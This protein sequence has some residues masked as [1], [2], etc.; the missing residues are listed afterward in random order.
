[1]TMP[2]ELSNLVKI[3]HDRL[4][5]KDLVK[6]QQTLAVGDGTSRAIIV[7]GKLWVNGSKLHVRFMGG[8]PAQQ[9][10]AQEQAKW[11][12]DHANLTFE[13]DNAPNAEI[14]IAFDSSDGA[15]SYIGTDASTIPMNQPTMNLG[16]LDGGTAAHEFG[17]A[18]GLAHEHQNPAGGIQWNE[19]AVIRD[20]S[21]P[22][23]SWDQATIRH[24]VLDKYRAD[25]IRGTE[26]DHDSIMLYFFPDAWVKNGKGTKANEVL[27]KLDKEFVASAQVYPKTTTTPQGVELKIGAPPTTAQIGVPGEEDL[28]KFTVTSSS[29]YV[30]ETG[31]QTDVAMKLFGPNSQ[32][33]LINEDD[34]G[35]I[36]FNARIASSLIP[37]EYFV[38]IRHF[39]KAGGIGSYTIKVS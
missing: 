36:G 21:G 5:P 8:T 13:F 28:F 16:F 3:C 26:F 10:I 12:T 9:A 33:R 31:G 30:I 32:T 23:N 18:I 14:R 35:G 29:R 27:S 15:W 34:D 22:P 19:D 17:H 4:L 6:P 39:N 37:G 38:Q 11:W 24:N 2:E 7:L 20:L 1:M 25:Q